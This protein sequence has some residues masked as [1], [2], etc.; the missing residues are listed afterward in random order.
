MT[1]TST[2]AGLRA[3]SDLTLYRL[4]DIGYEIHL[5][6][7]ADLLSANHPE[8][9]RPS[10]GGAQAIQIPNPPLAVRLGSER[11]P[12]AGS[13]QDVEFSA[14]LFDFGV[15][16]LR[17]RIP[18]EARDWGELVEWSAHVTSDPEWSA[19][20]LRWRD[21]LIGLIGSA[22]TKAGTSEVTEDYSV[23]RIH[24]LIDGAGHPVVVDELGEEA[25][26]ALLF[27]EQRPLSAS[28][29]RDSMSPRFSYYED[30][31][32]VLAWNAALIVEPAPE[33][34]DVEYV[35]EFANAQ[36]LELRY[37]DSVLDHEIPRIYDEI[38]A[39]RKAFRFLGRHYSRL[40]ATLQTRVADATEL[41]ERVENSLKVTED[42]HL[43]RIYSTAL[44]IFRGRTWRSGI[45]RKVAI[46][47][48]AYTMLNAETLARRSEVLEITIIGLIL[49][50]LILALVRR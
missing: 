42:V 5:E 12:C 37:Y 13:T 34:T 18:G 2:P 9:L 25:I 17:A 33:D 32:A 29:R 26:A 10:R 48:E 24:Q 36:L 3:R 15:V 27:G 44:E 14:R 6:H 41:V 43:A 28:A 16:S 50:E 30:D 47:R 19:C 20:F 11:V 22:I 1:G 45:D 38:E 46:V 49:L 7:A 23:F 8:R 39:T 31:L 4:Y 21:R 35:L 40:L